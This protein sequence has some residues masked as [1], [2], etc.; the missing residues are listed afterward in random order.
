VEKPLINIPSSGSIFIPGKVSFELPLVT[1]ASHDPFLIPSKEQMESALQEEKVKESEESK[2]DSNSTEIGPQVKPPS[3]PT[4]L[5]KPKENVTSEEVL[6]TFTIP[7]L[8]ME[9]A[10]PTPEVITTSV[11]AAGTA[12]LITVA[13]GMATQTAVNYLK[14]IFKKIFTKVL[15]KEV[16]EIQKTSDSSSHN[17]K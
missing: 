6:A 13:G 7:L 16:K 4:N 12:S 10:I 5:P 2:D 17:S 8:G 11:V 14:K 9:M 3:I 15:K 1:P